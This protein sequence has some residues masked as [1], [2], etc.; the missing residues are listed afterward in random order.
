[1]ASATS[2][3]T[4]LKR[5]IEPRK[6]RLGDD[7]VVFAY[8]IGSVDLDA[9]QSIQLKQT[10]YVPDLGCNLISV[11][12]AVEANCKVIFENPGYC[13]LIDK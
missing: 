6:V 2:A 9:T 4:T 1:M 13:E 12:K 11:G 3:F 8:G 10:L 5:L 7:T